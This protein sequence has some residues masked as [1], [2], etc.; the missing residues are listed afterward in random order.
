MGNIIA[1]QNLEN[2]KQSLFDDCATLSELIQTELDKEN[3]I[4]LSNYILQNLE[5]NIKQIRN[6]QQDVIRIKKFK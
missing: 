3:F 6:L 2:L 4:Q 5:G 1:V